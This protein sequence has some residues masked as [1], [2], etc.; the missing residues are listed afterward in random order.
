VNDYS[1]VLRLDYYETSFLFT[2]DAEKTSEMEMI[3]TWTDGKLDCDVLKVGHHGSGTS[4]NLAF[5]KLV[6]PE[7]AVISCGEDNKYG[8]PHADALAR[9][10]GE[11][12]PV[13]RTDLSGS[14][15]VASDGEKVIYLQEK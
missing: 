14:I 1:V 15:R 12:I 3:E 8:H 7:L 6:T 9:L 13:Y 2:G 4:T 10:K 11:Q 5:L